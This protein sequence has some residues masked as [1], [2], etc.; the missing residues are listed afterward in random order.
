MLY[1]RTDIGKLRTLSS[2]LTVQSPEDSEIRMS[3]GTRYKS[4]KC[5]I[6][7]S[8]QSSSSW[9]EVK[10]RYG[11]NNLVNCQNKTPCAKLQ[12]LCS[13]F[14]YLEAHESRKNDQI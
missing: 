10:P 14:T 12:Q 6:R 8:A 4:Y 11:K 2:S 1:S 5:V 7:Q 3:K 9:S 13:T